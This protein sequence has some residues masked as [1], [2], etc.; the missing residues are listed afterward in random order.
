MIISLPAS[1][2]Q[3]Y[4]ELMAIIEPDLTTTQLPLLREKYNNESPKETQVRAERY[5]KAYGEYDKQYDC[6]VRNA[7]EQLNQYRYNAFQSLEKEDR[8]RDQA[9]LSVLEATL[10]TDTTTV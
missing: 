2:Q 7:K 1:G 9:K 10:L 3:L 6:F 4:D 8:A 5:T